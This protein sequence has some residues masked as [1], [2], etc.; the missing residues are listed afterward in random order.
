MFGGLLDRVRGKAVTIPPLDGPLRAN[1]AIDD[2]PALCEA[3]APDDLAF[4]GTSFLFSS[5]D[6]VQALPAD[7]TGAPV[8]VARFDVAVTALAGAADGSVAVALDDGRIMIRGGARDGLALA[9]SDVGGLAC[10]TALAFAGDGALLVCQG[11]AGRRPSD[12]V[13][14][15][16]EK[17]ASG[18]VWRID[19]AAGRAARLAGD[20]AFPYG[21]LADA[22]GGGIVVAESWRH[23][24]VR[25]PASGGAPVPVLARLPG[26]PAR[27]APAADGGAWL[28]L[29]APRNRLI[30]FVLQE[31][32]YRADM[33]R[34]VARPYWIAPALSSGSSFLEP[35]QCGGVKTMGIHKPWS[36]SRSYG[37]LVRLDRNLR[38]VASFHS[39]ANGRR[40]GVTGAI[41]RDG[42]VL[43]AAKGG[44]AILSLAAP[45]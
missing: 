17:G 25:V 4:D 27:L 45:S 7:G 34:D 31:D 44:S 36:P 33:M 29:F 19:L 16:M 3:T 18:S 40:H 6:T 26:Y 32:A 12:W 43:V 1:T 15:L 35:L 11:A 37:L 30:E 41:E 21:V 5:G 9:P 38:P 20:L 39:R 8:P 10:P 24:L 23:R 42:R 22:P 13:V 14:D 28:C 2:A